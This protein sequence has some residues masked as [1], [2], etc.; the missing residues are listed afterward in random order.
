MPKVPFVDQDECTGD[1]ICVEICPEVFR[2]NDDGLAEVHDP[3]GAP[4][5]K[6]QEAIDECPA[7]CIHW[8]ED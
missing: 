3:N 7:T 1:E 6:I 8:K 4:E 5:D 2:M